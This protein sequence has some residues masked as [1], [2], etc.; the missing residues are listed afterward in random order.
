MSK[1][2]QLYVKEGVYQT[3]LR[4]AFSAG[5]AV[6]VNAGA[7]PATADKMP[8]SAAQ[9]SKVLQPGASHLTA[10]QALVMGDISLDDAN[11][12]I[13]LQSGVYEVEISLALLAA[14]TASD[15]SVALT[16]AAQA[17]NDVV[18]ANVTGA[19]IAAAEQVPF[20]TVQYISVPSGTSRALELHVAWTTAAATGT[21]RPGSFLKVSR[22]GNVE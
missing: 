4:H 1:Q 5:T 16:T 3:G 14:G 13:L 17:A 18:Y 6:V 20:R 12:R 8:L 7:F 22:L 11:D 15:F 10:A 21:I 9:S 2:S 19:T